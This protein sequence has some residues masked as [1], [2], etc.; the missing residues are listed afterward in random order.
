MTGRLPAQ[1]EART[2]K[3]SAETRGRIVQ[4][5]F[6]SAGEALKVELW[7]DRAVRSHRTLTIAIT[8]VMQHPAGKVEIPAFPNSLARRLGSYSDPAPPLR[9]Q[10]DASLPCTGRTWHVM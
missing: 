8:V 4:V 2:T 10:V 1:P 6:G 9:S 3:R 5:E 7:L